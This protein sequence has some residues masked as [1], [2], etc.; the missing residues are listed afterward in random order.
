MASDP[1]Q[2]NQVQGT[3]VFADGVMTFTTDIFINHG[4]ASSCKDGSSTNTVAVTESHNGQLHVVVVCTPNSA[5]AAADNTLI[6]G[7]T[8]TA[9]P[10]A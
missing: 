4:V 7:F 5:I 1:N 3:V 9:S 2:P 8:N 10:S 6:Q